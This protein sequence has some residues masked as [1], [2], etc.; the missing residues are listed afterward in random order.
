MGIRNEGASLKAI[1]DFWIWFTCN[2]E[3]LLSLYRD[4]QFEEL[5]HQVADELGKIDA[6]L[7]WEMGPGK[8]TANLLT[9]SAEGNPKLCGLAAL[10]IQLAPPLRGWEFYSSRPPRPA[11]AIVRLPESGDSFETAQ[12]Q[13][14]PVENADG[15]RLDLLIV[16]DQLAR[17]DRETALRAV[18]IYLDEMLGEDMVQ[19]WIGAFEIKNRLATHGKTTYKLIELPDYLEWATNRKRNPLAKDDVQ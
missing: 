13:F 18:S 14:V 2:R 11:P 8:K 4:E 6:G 19:K 1:G 12:W 15:G 16:D 5:G 7:S 3:K 17:S 9:I 10:M